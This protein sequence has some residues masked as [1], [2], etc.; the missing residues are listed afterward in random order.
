MLTTAHEVMSIPNIALIES[1]KY[2]SNGDYYNNKHV[3]VARRTIN[4]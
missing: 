1:L 4:M 2:M 3:I